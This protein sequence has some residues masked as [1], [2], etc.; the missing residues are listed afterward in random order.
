[1]NRYLSRR[2]FCAC[3]SCAVPK[4]DF[5]KCKV[6]VITGNINPVTVMSVTGTPMQPMTRTLTAFGATLAAGEFRAVNVAEDE[7][8]LEGQYWVVRLVEGMV[9]ADRDF[10]YGGETILKGFLVAKAQWLQYMKTDLKGR[11]TYKLLTEE[12]YMNVNAFLRIDALTIKEGTAGSTFELEA[13][14]DQRV[15]NSTL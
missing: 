8:Q 9:V 2:A 11:R 4:C 13:D 7:K 10:T 15:L 3:P 1:L 14:E 6:N 5:D 12:R